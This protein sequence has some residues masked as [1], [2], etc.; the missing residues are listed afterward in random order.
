MP[1]PEVVCHAVHVHAT[2]VLQCME[3]MYD[4]CDDVHG[5]FYVHGMM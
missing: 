2:S 3:K 1:M 4:R 5:T